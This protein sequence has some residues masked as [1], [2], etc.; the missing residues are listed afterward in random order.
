MLFA[1]EVH[2]ELLKN[3]V[4]KKCLLVT[5]PI[6]KVVLLPVGGVL[7]NSITTP[8]RGGMA[9]QRKALLNVVLNLRVRQSFWFSSETWLC[10]YSCDRKLL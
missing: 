4:W 1:K 10:F 9:N 7:L 2:N 8:V 3:I 6:V 5:P